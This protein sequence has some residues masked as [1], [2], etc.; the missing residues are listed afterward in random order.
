MGLFNGKGL[1]KYA[2]GDEYEGDYVNDKKE[3]IGSYQYKNG[4]LYVG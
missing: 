1:Y 2:N 3:G 4:E